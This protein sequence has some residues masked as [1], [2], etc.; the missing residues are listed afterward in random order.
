MSDELNGGL[1]AAPENLLPANT[2]PVNAAEALAGRVGQQDGVPIWQRWRDDWYA[3]DGHR[4]APMRRESLEQWL[5][6]QTKNA[7]FYGEK[8]EVKPWEPTSHRLRELEHALGTL[9]LNRPADDEPATGVFCLNGMV[10]GRT[11]VPHHAGRFNILALPFDYDAFAECPAWLEFLDQV[12]PA[13][14]IPLLQQWF[15]YVISG[16]TSR[17]KILSLVGKPRSGKG[18][19]GRILTK[20]LGPD[21]VSSPTLGSL[22]GTFGL[23]P[24]LGK[25]LALIG[26]AR[27]AGVR[28][29]GDAVE[30]LKGVSGEDAMTVHRKNRTAWEGQ[31]GVRFMIMSNDPPAFTDASSAL[32]GRL[33]SIVTQESFAGREDLGLEDRLTTELPGILNWALDGLGDLGAEQFVVPES[34]AQ[35]SRDIAEEASPVLAWAGDAVELEPDH[36][37][38]MDVLYE[39]FRRWAEDQGHTHLPTSANFSRQLRSVLGS[40]VTVAPKTM[41]GGQRYR[42]VLGLRLRPAPRW[43]RNR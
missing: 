28:D 20:L 7:E 12:L 43:G 17:H 39:H 11:L 1:I 38:R 24:L 4:W 8:L 31:L 25:S 13:D 41:K 5:M 15:G 40:S 19:I 16:D 18:T 3:W 6:L 14:Q 21:L 37:E 26:D 23:Q 33:L 2:D 34:S 9:Y 22:T 32:A 36:E 27:W 29:L 30:L 10:D 35:L 42:P